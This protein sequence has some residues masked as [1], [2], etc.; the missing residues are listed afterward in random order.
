[1]LLI[2]DFLLPTAYLFLK[3]AAVWAVGK[4]FSARFGHDRLTALL[5]GWMMVNAGQNALILGL[6]AFDALSQPLYILCALFAVAAVYAAMRQSRFPAISEADVPQARLILA[7]GLLAI[8][9]LLFWLRAGF[10][11]DYTW[12]AQ[13]YGV[14]RLA[15]WL[16]YG[17][18]FV[19][20]PTI[21]LNLFVNEWNGELNALAYGLAAGSYTAFNYANLE[22]LAGFMAVVFWLARLF[23]APVLNALCLMLILG[24]MPAILG[25]ASTLKGD[26]LGCV[27]LLFAAG[28][29]L[30]L[31]RGDRSGVNLILLLLAASWALG[32]KISVLLPLLVLIIV[33][34]LAQRRNLTAA[35]IGLPRS[36]LLWAGAGLLIFSSRFWANWFVYGN[37]LQRVDAEK[38][39]FQPGY[40]LD[41]LVLAFARIF[42]GLIETPAN[43][44]SWALSNDMGVAAWF[45]SA[46]L[47]LWVVLRRFTNA[48]ASAKAKPAVMF[49]MPGLLPLLLAGIA[50]AV[51][52]TM[53]L[54]PAFNWNFR[55]FLPG[56]LLL[57]IAA[58]AR[59]QELPRWHATPLLIGSLLVVVAN[60]ALAVRPGEIFL[61][62]S[63]SAP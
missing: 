2:T 4:G 47:L 32:A 63:G 26:L 34:G 57:F 45:L 49:A 33:A 43:H 39:V 52:A 28:W 9:L 16:N 44:L 55:Y 54:T 29:L 5:A 15:I 21:Q 51:L 25:L 58:G 13:T 18:V 46:A 1:M 31:L 59:L 6:S 35:M 12:D 60:V 3:V 27:G 30:R 17:T 42:P 19:H 61:M 38:V 24:S 48:T 7:L 14:P 8:L 23:G 37:P 62:W 40:V 22:V 20:M 11:A 56:L 10:G 36:M 50:M 41:N 53:F